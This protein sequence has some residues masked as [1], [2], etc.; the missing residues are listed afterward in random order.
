[1]T[2]KITSPQSGRKIEET[3]NSY[4]DSDNN[5]KEKMNESLQPVDDK[6]DSNKKNTIDNIK[7]NSFEQLKPNSIEN[8][9]S[10]EEISDNLSDFLN[11]S[12]SKKVI[13]RLKRKRNESFDLKE[14]YI[15][16][17]KRKIDLLIE[18]F[19]S[20]NFEANKTKISSE[21]SID[22][23]SSSNNISS[24]DKILEKRD[25]TSD[26]T[27][28]TKYKSSNKNI[29]YSFAKFKL[30]RK[31][32]SLK[33]S[34][35][36]SKEEL[37][38][39]KLENIIEN[40]K[41]KR[42]VKIQELRENNIKVI[43]VGFENDEFLNSQDVVYDIFIQEG[44]TNERPKDSSIPIIESFDD[45]L[46]DSDLSDEYDSE[47]SNAEN[48]PRN[49]Y[50]YESDEEDHE[51]DEDNYDLPGEKFNDYNENNDIQSDNSDMMDI[52]EDYYQKPIKKYNSYDSDSEDS[53]KFNKKGKNTKYNSYED[54][55]DEEE[56]EEFLN[57]IKSNNNKRKF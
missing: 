53:L 47:D 3:S 16:E 44:I 38:K 37:R 39:D 27:I 12:P 28:D 34:S 46:A 41:Q 24:K 33:Q 11:N 56:F 48:N 35:L 51:E 25:L 45:L 40:R 23:N 55:T 50:G 4:I 57:L 26:K 13:L 29:N 18:K 36:P 22:F 5:L 43:E 15:P 32:I 6:K 10:N 54:E 17:K 19:S 20:F 30:V 2:D 14:F 9:I 49:D 8:W 7:D 31:G 1:M 21:K 42:L 52:D